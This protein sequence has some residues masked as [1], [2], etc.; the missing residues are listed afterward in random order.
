M[1]G[2]RG[3]TVLHII[4]TLDSTS[5]DTLLLHDDLVVKHGRGRGSVGLFKKLRLVFFVTTLDFFPLLSDQ[6]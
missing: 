6:H 1:V 4:D 2:D 3:F 5:L